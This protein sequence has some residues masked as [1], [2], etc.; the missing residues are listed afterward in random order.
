MGISQHE[1]RAAKNNLDALEPKLA[2][3]DRRVA[4][5]SR[6]SRP[7]ARVRSDRI[8]SG[9]RNTRGPKGWSAVRRRAQFWKDARRQV[10]SE[11][12]DN[13]RLLQRAA[14]EW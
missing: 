14:H 10:V 8:R 1:V 4:E 5:L 11:I 6:K 3:I 9:R 7:I 13:T 12:R 2:E